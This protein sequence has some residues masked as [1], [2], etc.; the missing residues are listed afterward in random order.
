MR[1]PFL[2]VDQWTSDRKQDR[3]SRTLNVETNGFIQFKLEL[4]LASTYSLAI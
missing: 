3:W 4:V 1:P 2:I